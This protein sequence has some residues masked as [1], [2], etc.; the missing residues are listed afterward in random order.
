VGASF[1]AMIFSS[2]FARC[3]VRHVLP[4][5]R[6]LA[7]VPPPL[8]K[9]ATATTAKRSREANSP[10]GSN[11]VRTSAFLSVYF[12]EIG[13]NRINDHE[14]HVAQMRNGFL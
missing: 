11:T 5:M 3:T 14:A 1:L 4:M 7:E 2:C 13:A 10:M 12:A 9:C 6:L 8:L